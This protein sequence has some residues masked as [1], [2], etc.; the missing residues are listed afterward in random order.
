MDKQRHY[1][2]VLIFN[3]IH[4]CHRICKGEYAITRKIGLD[5]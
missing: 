5:E 4:F 1:L 2:K 3:E